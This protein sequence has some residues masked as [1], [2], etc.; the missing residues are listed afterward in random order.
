MKALK[1]LL[2]ITLIITPIF[3]NIS[4]VDSL[5]LTLGTL[6]SLQI[7]GRYDI[8]PN[9]GKYIVLAFVWISLIMMPSYHLV[10]HSISSYVNYYVGQ[11]DFDRL[12]SFGALLFLITCISFVMFGTK[13]GKKRYC[14]KQY[15]PKLIS[16]LYIKLFFSLL[17]LIV[18][19]SYIEGVSRMSGEVVALPFHLGGIINF[20]KS[21]VVPFL[22]AALVENYILNKK[23]LPRKYFVLYFVYMLC[24]TFVWMSKGILLNY[25]L[26]LL[27]VLVLYYRPNFNK[28]IKYITPV[29][30]LFLF[31]YPIIG[32][33]RNIDGGSLKENFAEAKNEA[34]ENATEKP[35]VL[36]T[37]L[38][39][40]FM[41]GYQF[42]T[43]Y[44]Y[45]D[46]S[47][48]F[49]F[50]RLPL[51]IIYRGAQAYQTHVIDGYPEDALTSSG[52]SGIMDPL[53]HGGYGLCYIVIILIMFIASRVDMLYVK[54]QF[55]LYTIL[56]L[57]IWRLVNNSNLSSLYDS[58]GLQSYLVCLISFC[59][60]YYLNFQKKYILIDYNQNKAL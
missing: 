22:F 41:T 23:A 45:I 2:I 25:L 17:F 16:P 38:N 27:V 34:D 6:M 55:S 11:K 52:T 60:A 57:V 56:V 15:C 40:T 31:L 14:C 32:I 1:I 7:L 33:M 3:N 30:I 46:K 13:S 19:I 20:F 53:L 26:P 21:I 5:L 37:V 18:V 43:D 44:D 12:L 48:F 42:A 28:M 35:F 9:L 4:L 54:R 36:I 47:S 58:I 10:V 29:F 50:S 24:E 8:L 59:L 39:R 49:D 51:L